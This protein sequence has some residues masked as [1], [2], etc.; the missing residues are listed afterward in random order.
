ME[1]MASTRHAFKVRERRRGSQDRQTS[2]HQRPILS[3]K[4]A[5][6][7]AVVGADLGQLTPPPNDLDGGG[8]LT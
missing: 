3:P 5:L 4:A 6:C 2:A 1:G 8:S 7:E